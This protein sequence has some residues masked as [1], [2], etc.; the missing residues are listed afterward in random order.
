MTELDNAWAES[1]IEAMADGSLSP[2]AERRMLAVMRLDEGVAARVKQARA[3]Q[4][5]LKQL[6]PAPVPKRLVWRLWRIPSRDRRTGG[7]VWMP[8][9]FVA[10]AASVA[11]T[12]NIF[13]GI[14]GP[15]AEEQAQAAA[16]EDFTIVM[17]YLQK[18]ALMAT[19]EVNEAVGSGVLDALA[20]SRGMME[21]K[22]TEVSQGD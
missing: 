16:V 20:V 18:S 5:A 10:A 2:Q 13:F 4:L 11:L 19:N 17:A 9:A 21:R 6:K 1:Q 3:L 7:V 14:S 22:E 15:T 12:L 8:V